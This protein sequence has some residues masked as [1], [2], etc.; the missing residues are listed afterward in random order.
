M[1]YRTLVDAATL[2]A[3]R[4]DPSWVVLDCRFSLADTEQG[5]RLYAQGHIPGAGYVHLDEDLSGTISADTGRHPLPDS[6][7]VAARLGALGIAADSQVVLYD[8][9]GGAMAAR[10]WWLLRSLGHTHVAVLDGG[11]PAWL[12][13]GQSVTAEAPRVT[14]KAFQGTL[15]PAAVVTTA[16]VLDN[17][18]DEHFLLVDARSPERFRGE[19]EP[20]DPVAGRIPGAINRPLQANL[21]AQGRFLPPPAL[22]AA[23]S[24]LLGRWSPDAVVHM[25]G[26]GITACHNLLAMEHAGLAGSRVYAGSW[27]EWIR[28][29][30]RPVATTGPVVDASSAKAS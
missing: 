1:S 3:H 24:T 10:G 21:D 25:C 2:A 14:P 9:A 11:L 29:S 12:A 7:A 30:E 26:S 8:D 23:W 5:R 13:A 6:A 22:K 17:L 4:E 16:Q 20:I 27:S 28:D 18:R 19:E 15:D